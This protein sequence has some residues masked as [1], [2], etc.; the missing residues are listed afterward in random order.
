MARHLRKNR[1]DMFKFKR[2]WAGRIEGIDAKSSAGS[3]DCRN[4]GVMKPGAREHIEYDL[5]W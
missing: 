3:M 2:R 5:Y 1:E 4:L